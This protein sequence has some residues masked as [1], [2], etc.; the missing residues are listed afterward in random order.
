MIHP[1]EPLV[2]AKILISDLSVRFESVTADVLAVDRISLTVAENEFVCIMGPSGCGKTTVLNTIAGIVVP[3]S[4]E[5]YVGNEPVRGPGPDRAMVFQE[6]A[7]FPWMTVEQNVGYSLRM[8][9]RPPAEIEKVVDRY[10]SL[11]GLAEFRKAWPRELSGGMKKRVDL[12]RGYAADPEVL[13]MDEPFGA[14][15]IMTKERLQEEFY[16]LW[17]LAPR[18]VVFITHDLEEALFLGDRVIL[19]SP[20]PGRID[21]EHR[22]NFPRERD[23][24]LKTTPEFVRFAKQLRKELQLQQSH[25]KG[26]SD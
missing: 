4:G 19:M 10:V 15:D 20:R 12:A 5:V 16:K 18:T 23:M 21:A 7:V 3:T 8:R 1:A 11:V 26:I 22:P 17:L 13:L 2:D 6:D 9:G 25:P 24:A 14:L